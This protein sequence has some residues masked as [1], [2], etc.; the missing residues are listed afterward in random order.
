MGIVSVKSVSTLVSTGGV[1]A[2]G[3][4]TE[5]IAEIVSKLQRRPIQLVHVWAGCFQ[6]ELGGMARDVS[7][8]RS[9]GQTGLIEFNLINKRAVER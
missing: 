7:H 4:C 6:P 1:R 8:C 5:A 2:A 9:V 3:D